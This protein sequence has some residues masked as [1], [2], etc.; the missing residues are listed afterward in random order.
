MDQEQRW[1][2][3]LKDLLDFDKPKDFR[4]TLTQILL[5]WMEETDVYPKNKD[6]LIHRMHLLI[7]FFDKLDEE[8]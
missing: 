8:K 4:K 5:E 7:D 6:I 2:N 3:E 1:T